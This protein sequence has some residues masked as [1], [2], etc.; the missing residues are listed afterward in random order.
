MIPWILQ[1]SGNL[2]IGMLVFIV[3]VL[4]LRK[5]VYQM[6]TKKG[7]CSE[8]CGGCSVSG[9]C[10]GKVSLYDAYQKDKQNH[11]V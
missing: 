8:S 7:F 10:S 1:N 11:L 2:I 3:F 5:L 6:A 4:K 9:V